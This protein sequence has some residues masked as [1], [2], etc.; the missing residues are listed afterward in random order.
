MGTLGDVFQG[1]D[2]IYDECVKEQDAKGYADIFKQAAEGTFKAIKEETNFN[3][4]DVEYLDGY[5]IFGFGT[6][7]VVHFKIKECPGW[8]FGIWWY[9]PET[10]YDK[11]DD[12]VIQEKKRKCI[13]GEFFGQYE[14][15]IDKFKPSHSSYH[16]RITFDLDNLIKPYQLWEFNK[17]IEFIHKEPYLAFYKDLYSTDFN[18]KYVTRR[19]AKK[20]FKKC[21]RQEKIKSILKPIYHKSILRFI[22]RHCE[23]VYPGFEIFDR[24]ECWSPRYDVI[25]DWDESIRDIYIK[26]GCYDLFSIYD[27][28]REARLN[29][30]Y[31]KLLKRW[32][33]LFDKFDIWMFEPVGWCIDIIDKSEVE[34]ESIFS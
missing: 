8:K 28:K 3:I 16:C 21:N 34:D 18:T 10:Y 26:P 15:N 6:N 2:D 30:K 23:K 27:E 1:I 14:T 29:K 11:T 17:I 24:G 33:C 12:G 4:T 20:I 5:F 22:R 7:S 13:V 25:A 31:K 32:E 19:K 9:E